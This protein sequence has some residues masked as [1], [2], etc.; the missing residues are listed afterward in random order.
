MPSTSDSGIELSIRW[1]QHVLAAKQLDVDDVAAVVMDVRHCAGPF[2]LGYER[3]A[4]EIGF[5]AHR[6]ESIAK[7]RWRR[8]YTRKMSPG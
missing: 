8:L 1:Y 6:L 2:E 5:C 7:G 3:G 4:G